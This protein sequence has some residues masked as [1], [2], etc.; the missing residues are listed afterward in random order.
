MWFASDIQSLALWRSGALALWCSA[1]SV[2]DCWD[3]RSLQGSATLV[4]GLSAAGPLHRCLLDSRL[5]QR[6]AISALSLFVAC[7]LWRFDMSCFSCTFVL[8][9]PR[10][11]SNF[12]ASVQRLTSRAL[13][14]SSDRPQILGHYCVLL[15]RHSAQFCASV[16]PGLLPAS[17]L[18]PHARLILRSAAP[19]GQPVLRSVL[20]RS[21]A[22]RLWL[23]RS[24]VAPVPQRFWLL[25]SSVAAVPSGS[26]ARLLR[27]SA[28]PPDHF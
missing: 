2:L 9:I 13:G 8:C 19:L 7:P 11:Y 23:L 6:L 10:R 14:L 25:R 20:R 15:L 18:G 21:G 5:L 17:A 28:V 22:Q 4:L 16:I 3:A 26:D 12:S 24:S 27:C 1:T